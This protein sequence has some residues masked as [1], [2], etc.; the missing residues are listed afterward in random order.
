MIIKSERK[1]KSAVVDMTPLE[2]DR[3][4]EKYI[5]SF[6]GI[7]DISVK[8]A[9]AQTLPGLKKLKNGDNGS[10]HLNVHSQA[11]QENTEGHGYG[12]NMHEV[13]QILIVS[14]PDSMIN[15]GMYEVKNEALTQLLEG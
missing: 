14:I 8:T 6:P 15:L 2:L 5:R 4:A 13:P 1:S 11:I 9:G 10:I 7:V 12:R 3:I